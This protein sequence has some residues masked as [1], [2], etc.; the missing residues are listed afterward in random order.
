MVRRHHLLL[1]ASIGSVPE[2]SAPDAAEHRAPASARPPLGPTSTPFGSLAAIEVCSRHKTRPQHHLIATS[3]HQDFSEKH[4]N[5]KRV[6]QN[7]VG[8][9]ALERV[10]SGRTT[11]DGHL[12][13][14]VEAS[15]VRRLPPRFRKTFPLPAFGKGTTTSGARGEATLR[16]ALFRVLS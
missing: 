4:R 14:E 8:P 12:A 16:A 5:G 15:E 11:D 2:L 13:S 10:G 3:R 1:E 9:S 7:A 6:T